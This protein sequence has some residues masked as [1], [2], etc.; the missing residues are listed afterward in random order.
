MSVLDRLE[1]A[2]NEV[3][4]YVEE[5]PCTWCK[6]KAETLARAIEDLKDLHRIGEE[7]VK[8]INSKQSLFQLE[9]EAMK[10][11]AMRKVLQEQAPGPNPGSPQEEVRVPLLTFRDLLEV[12]KLFPTPRDA[13]AVMFP[14]PGDIR[15]L[16]NLLRSLVP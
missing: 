2:V 16:I 3:R 6:A 13:F 1:R 14:K 9:E 7:Y 15:D 11:G 8:K 5:T 12:V 4:R 10:L